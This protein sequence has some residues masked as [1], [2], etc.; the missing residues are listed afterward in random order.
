MSLPGAEFVERAGL[1]AWPGIDVEY[2]GQWVLRAAQGY[3]KRANSV[4]SL[5]VTD[6]ANAAE[7]IAA[8]RAWF[9]M[10]GLQPVFRVTPLAG[11]GI[12]AALD[13]AGWK[14]IDAS[15][16]FAMELGSILPDPRG[17]IYPILD[18]TFLAVAQRLQR[19]SDLQLAAMKA[20]LSVI[21][22]PA[23]GVI[24]Y[25][26]TGAPVA[27][28]LFDIADGIVI[29]GNVV[30][31]AAQRRKGYGAAMMR[32]GLSWAHENGATVA[33]LNVAAD[34]PVGQALYRSLGYER[35]YDYAYRVPAGA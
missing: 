24:L 10:R 2:D 13:D 20:L 5:D 35:Q 28:A 27:S 26:E 1:K 18:K 22:V 17:E 21:E 11:P 30:T 9:E 6:E 8:S 4:Q 25:S 3:T 16:L 32:T 7:R 34:N 23:V 33:A 19:Y 12:V 31:D 14:T 15:H 29:T